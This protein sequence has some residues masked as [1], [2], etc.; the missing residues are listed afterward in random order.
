MSME[1]ETPAAPAASAQPQPQQKANAPSMQPLLRE[2]SGSSDV[3]EAAG[4]AEKEVQATLSADTT[5]SSS[6][7]S[8]PP[9][10]EYPSSAQSAALALT[11]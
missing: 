1:V 2:G 8:R 9:S 3:M 4:A 10:D 6:N 11:P 7:E 5:T